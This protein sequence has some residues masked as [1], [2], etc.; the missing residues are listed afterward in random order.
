MSVVAYARIPSGVAISLDIVAESISSFRKINVAEDAKRVGHILI[1]Q[2][3]HLATELA[4]EGMIV[5]ARDG[6]ER[7]VV[8][9]GIGNSQQVVAR[10]RGEIGHGRCRTAHDEW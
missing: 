2:V 8:A 3:E 9:G 5:C 1:L 4:G 7:F 6:V 10:R